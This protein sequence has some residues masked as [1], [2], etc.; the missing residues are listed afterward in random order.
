MSIAYSVIALLFGFSLLI[1]GAD[2]FVDGAAGLAKVLSVSPLIIGVSIVGFGTSAPEMLVSA[3]SAIDGAPQLGI[4]NAIGSNIANIGLVLAITIL[5]YP[6]TIKGNALNQEFIALTGIMSVSTLLMIDGTLSFSDGALLLTG[7]IVALAGMTY[8][9]RQQYT[10]ASETDDT[11]LSVTHTILLL[12][13]GLI[14]LLVGAK[15]L[16]SGATDLARL[17]GVSELII[18]LTIIAIGTSLPELA[19]TLTAAKKQEHSMAIGNILGSNMFNLLAV[20]AMPGLILPSQI[21]LMVL[22]RDIPIMT[23]LFIL[24]FIAIKFGQSG[25]ISRQTGGILLLT[26]LAYSSYLGYLTL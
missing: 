23:I 1:W 19:T 6:L 24:L 8:Q 22:Y 18:G 7:F 12:A 15:L 11:S 21:D 9:A 2:R 17:L 25:Y 20:L 26:Y 5:F 4:G 16:V 10:Q 14:A 3:L 13:F